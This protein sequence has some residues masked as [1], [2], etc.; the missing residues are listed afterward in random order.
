LP[1]EDEGG[2]LHHGCTRAHEGDVDVL[3][4]A[5]PGASGGLQRPLDDVPQTV[6][7]PG[8]E[9]PAEGVERQL[10][11]ELHAPA[12]DEIERFALLAE[13]VRLQAVDHRRGEAVVNLGHVD[14]AR[15]ETRALPG[16]ARRAAATFH[17]V[18]Q[19]PDAPGHL[20]SEPLTV[21]REICGAWP[22]VARAIG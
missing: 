11:V 6:K 10:A 1:H 18:A 19:A 13:P 21:A 12:L 9:A 3:D 15:A 4:L 14:V 22:Q 8:A 7:A 17:V 2:A 20:E 5:L 16:Q